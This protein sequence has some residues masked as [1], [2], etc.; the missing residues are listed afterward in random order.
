M[1]ESLKS[2]YSF[3]MCF[4]KYIEEYIATPT[5][6]NNFKCRA[7]LAGVFLISSIEAIA[8]ISATIFSFGIYIITLCNFSKF[9]I[10]GKETFRIS[11][12]NSFFS[13]SSIIGS[14]I[15][16]RCGIYVVAQTFEYLER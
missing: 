7:A 13:F 9:K 4:S 1:I 12:F 5:I 2:H 14:V 15:H 8:A 10:V 16:P 6:K 3:T 11:L